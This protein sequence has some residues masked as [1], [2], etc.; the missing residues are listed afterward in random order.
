MPSATTGQ[1]ERSSSFS[2]SSNEPDRIIIVGWKTRKWHAREDEDANTNVPVTQPR[3]LSTG[4]TLFHQTRGSEPSCT[5]GRFFSSYAS[6]LDAAPTTYST[7]RERMP[8]RRSSGRSASATILASEF[9][10]GWLSILDSKD[11]LLGQN[12]LSGGWHGARRMGQLWC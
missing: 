8:P 5:S 7:I 12:L 10:T 1:P 11:P 4:S 2:S 9:S 3:T 6:T